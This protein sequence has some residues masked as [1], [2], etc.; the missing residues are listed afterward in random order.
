M[1]PLT[2]HMI[3]RLYF[4][5]KSHLSYSNKADPKCVIDSTFQL[6]EPIRILHVI[7][8]LNHG[9]VESLLMNL[10]RNIDKTKVQFDF[11]ETSSEVGLYEEEIQKMGGKI[12]HCP[13]FEGKNFI[14]YH[15][16]WNAFF[17]KHKNEYAFV[18]GH[19]GSSAAI[20]LSAAK[21]YGIKTIAHSHSTYAGFNVRQTLYKLASYPTRYI[22]DYFFGCS[23]EAAES[24]YGKKVEYTIIKNAI[25]TER[26][27]FTG[28]R[29]LDFAEGNTVYGHIGRF[30][31]EKN[32]SFIIQ[33]FAEIHKTDPASVLILVGGG[34]L[35]DSLEK[36]VR[37][38]E[39][40]DCI[41]FLGA[42]DD[43]PEL[44]QSMD[45]MIFPSIYEGLPLTL[46]EG[47]CSGLR[48]LIS[49]GISNEAVLVPELITRMSLDDSAAE[50]AEKAVSLSKYERHS[51]DKNVKEA[52]FDIRNN[53]KW[54]EQFYLKEAGII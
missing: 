27:K 46:V 21:R 52:G 40:K 43:I 44:L 38:S 32:H 26:Y 30:T 4:W 53:A 49:D 9:G 5:K 13:R 17:E 34:P 19:I 8:L 10:Y 3:S 7:R 42:R 1:N 20:Y 22:A 12:Y 28:K 37:L 31:K 54:L 24:R 11:V 16:W 51:Y 45:L 18:H 15:G 39:L 50:W 14:E 2:Q 47:Q 6:E 25:D 29:T 33:V 35:K 36:E 41:Y 48:C 23:K